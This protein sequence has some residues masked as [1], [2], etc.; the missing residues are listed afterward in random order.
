MLLTEITDEKTLGQYLKVAVPGLTDICWTPPFDGFKAAMLLWRWLGP[1]MA[2]PGTETLYANLSPIELFQLVISE[3]GGVWCGGAAQIFAACLRSIG[4]PACAYVYG[5]NET[6]LTHATTIA[7]IPKDGQVVDRFILLDAYMGYFYIDAQTGEP[8]LFNALLRRVLN[9]QYDTIAM[10]VEPFQRPFI[11]GK[12]EDPKQRA[13]LFPKG[14]VPEVSKSHASVKVYRG[15]VMTPEKLLRGYTASGNIQTTPF[16][17]LLED[18][19]G[20]QS[21]HEFLLDLL[22]VKPWFD[23]MVPQF[24]VGATDTEFRNSI[25]SVLAEGLQQ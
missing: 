8:L 24:N 18:S 14:V 3:L 4:A 1:R 19:R 13:F 25:I 5:H 6:G 23:P 15:A 7:H 11:I 21:E 9:Q 12:N 20:D 16:G 10:H 2:Y 22:L 17:L